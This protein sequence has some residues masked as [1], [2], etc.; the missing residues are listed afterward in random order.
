MKNDKS[1]ISNQAYEVR[2]AA[3]HL[4]VPEW[5]IHFAKY[6]TGTN[7]R[8]TVYKWIEDNRGKDITIVDFTNNG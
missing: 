5:I 7:D 3:K 2:S 6:S 8:E 1:K 4:N